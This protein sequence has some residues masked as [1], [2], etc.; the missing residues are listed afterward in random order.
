MSTLSIFHNKIE[1]RKA[2][3]VMEEKVCAN[4]KHLVSEG[5]CIGCEISGEDKGETYYTDTCD[6]FE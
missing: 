2:F 3:K 5:W 4:C 6:K 1:I